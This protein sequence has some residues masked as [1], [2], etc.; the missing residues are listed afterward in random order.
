[1]TET[2]ETTSSVNP[3]SAVQQ[4]FILHWGEMGT[5]WGV[6]RTVAQVHALLYLSPKPLN[7][8]DIV[9]TL[10]VARS[11]VSTSLKELQAW[12]IVKLVHVLGDKRD[13]FESMKD[14]WEMFRVVMDE[15][16]KREF[17][18]TMRMLHECIA[19]AAKDK[20]TDEYTEHRLREL[21]RFFE[22]TSALYVQVR[23]WPTAA[24]FKFMK[25]GD[26]VLKVLGLGLP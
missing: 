12:G 25:A 4:K 5:R 9:E 13:H 17:D 22:T 20:A 6:N 11:N 23:R 7:A 18:P 8:D 21:Y 2:T 3:L 14:V 19:T 10:E 26:K 1:M 15:R 16:K 24:M